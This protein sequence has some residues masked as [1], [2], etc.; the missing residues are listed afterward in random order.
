LAKLKAFLRSAQARTLEAR[1]S[2]I[3]SLLD[4]FAPEECERP[5]F[6]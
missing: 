3:G 5:A 2:A 6:S 4:G 1:G